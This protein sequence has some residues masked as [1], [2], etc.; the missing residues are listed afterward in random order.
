MKKVRFS[1]QGQKSEK[2]Q[3]GVPFVVTYHL[4]LSKKSKK[5]FASGS[6]VSYRSA[7]KISI[8][9]VRAKLYPLERKFGSE[10]C[11]KSR[12]E[13]CLNIEE[14]DTFMSTTTGGSFK[15]NHKLNCDDN[16]LIYLLTCK[17]C[18][19]QYAG[20]STDEF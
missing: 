7:R 13:V 12:C 2:V 6:L 3:K 17:C 18:G 20:E 9:L 4:L 16:S 1:E 8:Y 11:D 5:I 10:K 14:T 15:I 19:K